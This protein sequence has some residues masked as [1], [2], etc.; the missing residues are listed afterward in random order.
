MV[1]SSARGDA[2]TSG[3][4]YHL[5][6]TIFHFSLD[7]ANRLRDDAGLLAV[8][9]HDGAEEVVARLDRRE[10]EPAVDDP[11]VLAGAVRD[12]A[13][14]GPE[15]FALLVLYDL[16]RDVQLRVFGQAIELEEADGGGI[17]RREGQLRYKA[18]LA[19]AEN[20]VAHLERREV[21]EL[22]VDLRV[23]RARLAVSGRRDAHPVRAGRDRQRGGHRRPRE[24]FGTARPLRDELAG[25]VEER[26]DAGGEF[27]AR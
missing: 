3:A 8:D 24:F 18:S 26:D 5:P 25:R 22:H 16:E 1:E 17:L 12:G 14:T 13:R 9:V 4:F 20:H 21:V 27:R 19:A 2:G 15:R 23:R 7:L 10:A 6:S 11:R